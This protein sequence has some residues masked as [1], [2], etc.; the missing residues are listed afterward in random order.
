MYIAYTHSWNNP[1]NGDHN[2][3]KKMNKEMVVGFVYRLMEDQTLRILGCR[4]FKPG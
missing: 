4:T 1:K 2:E 3:M